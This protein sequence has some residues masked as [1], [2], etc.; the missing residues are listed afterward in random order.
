MSDLDRRISLRDAPPAD[1]AGT[2]STVGCAALFIIG[3]VICGEL[4]WWLNR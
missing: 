4:S 2:Q 1:I 3:A